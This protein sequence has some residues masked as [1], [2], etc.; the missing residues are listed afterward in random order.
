[1]I[2]CCGNN[3]RHIKISNNYFLLGEC[4]KKCYRFDEAIVNFKKAKNILEINSYQNLPEYAHILYKL[5]IMYLLQNK[6][7]ESYDLFMHS[8]SIYEQSDIYSHWDSLV[9]LYEALQRCHVKINGSNKMAVLSD[10]RLA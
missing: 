4:L 6:D 9:G 10:L 7:N 5:G 1:M 8:I 2:Q 3:N